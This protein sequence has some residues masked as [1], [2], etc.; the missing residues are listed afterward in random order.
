MNRRIYQSIFAVLTALA[1]STGVACGLACSSG[2]DLSVQ[3][4][5][6]RAAAVSAS[7]AVAP[8]PMCG[9]CAP[10]PAPP[11]DAPCG[12][13]PG[14]GVAPSAVP[15]SFAPDPEA[16]AYATVCRSEETSEAGLN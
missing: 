8:A 7:V 1:A 3:L 6:A 12:G 14:L 16:F 15:L 5:A 11:D 4:S 13:V 10:V 2:G 9:S